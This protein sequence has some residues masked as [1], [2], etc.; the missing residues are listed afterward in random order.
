MQ[1]S[2]WHQIDHLGQR[3]STTFRHLLLSCLRFDWGCRH[4]RE[5]PGLV[6]E[7]QSWKKI[8]PLDGSLVSRSRKPQG[9]KPPQYQLSL[10]RSVVTV[11]S[12]GIYVFIRTWTLEARAVSL[13]VENCS[14][15]CCKPKDLF[16]FLSLTFSRRPSLAAPRTCLKLQMFPEAAASV[17]KI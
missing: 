16:L 13:C 11:G 7:M 10:C 5:N 8:A 14:S 6:D 17:W 1:D 3:L 9:S 4:L 15:V 2:V 12:Y